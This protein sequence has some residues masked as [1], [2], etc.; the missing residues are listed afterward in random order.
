MVWDY[1]VTGPGMVSYTKTP[2]GILAR[3]D[4][5]K[6]DSAGSGKCRLPRMADKR[7][8]RL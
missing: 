3:N 7:R 8:T 6:S 1:F 2:A 5:P 4:Q